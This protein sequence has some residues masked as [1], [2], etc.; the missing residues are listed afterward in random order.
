MLKEEL[1]QS[2]KESICKV[3][4]IRNALENEPYKVIHMDKMAQSLSDKLSVILS[5]V[6]KSDVR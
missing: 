1:V 4:S 2:L 3:Q 6:I 5:K